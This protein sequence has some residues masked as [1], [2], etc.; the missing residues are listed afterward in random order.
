MIMPDQLRSGYRRFRREQ[1]ASQEERYRALAE[2]QSPEVMVL[3]CADSRVDPAVIFNA[4]PGELF[5]VRNVAALAPPYEEAGSYHG[6][7]AALEFAVE[8]L[9]VKRIVVMGHGLCGG[10]AAALAA[11]E[12]RPVGR[13]IAPWVSMLTEVRDRLLEKTE[14]SQPA[15]R[16]KALE[17]M[18]VQQSLQNL[19]TFPFV[20]RA[21]ERGELELHGAWFSIADG[22]LHWLDW[23]TGVFELVEP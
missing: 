10:V 21:M 23:D 2:G 14:A 12:N 8:G 22:E 3:A 15:I 9:R 11:A 16:Q 18:G 6:T 13:F 17:R 1:F 19:T 5:V 20:T 7:S 4:G